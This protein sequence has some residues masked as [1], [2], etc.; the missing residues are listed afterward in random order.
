[1]NEFEDVP[2]NCCGTCAAYDKR[3]NTCR[4]EAPTMNFVDYAQWPMVFNT[5]WCL[6]WVSKSVE[7]PMPQ[8]HT[9]DEDKS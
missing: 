6:Q 7:T 2:E 5:D 4:R 8:M 3:K 9:I 1:M